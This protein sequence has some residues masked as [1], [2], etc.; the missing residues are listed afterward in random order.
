MESIVTSLVFD[1]ALRIRLKAETHKQDTSTSSDTSKT[2]TPDDAEGQGGESPK[3]GSD[4]EDDTETTDANSTTA[5]A[6]ST[7]AE[8]TASTAVSTA[9]AS[10]TVATTT[11]PKTADAKAGRPKDERKEKD[12]NLIG[13]INNLVTTDLNNLID[14]RD[15]L[16]VG[17]LFR[18][19]LD[20]KSVGSLIG[21]PVQS[22]MR[23]LK[24][25]CLF[26]SSTRSLAGGKQCP[27]LLKLYAKTCR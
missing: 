18:F 8:T 14:G 2:D 24:S 9:T 20:C 26:T 23:L 3:N 1:H 5:H 22:C 27:T 13:K 19:R 6:R 4:E 12:S 11:P 10:T 25:L 17:A 21:D 16:F 15:F 7:T